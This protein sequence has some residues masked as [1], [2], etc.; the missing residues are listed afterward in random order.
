MARL[1]RKSSF[2]GKLQEDFPVCAHVC[3]YLCRVRSPP[4]STVAMSDLDSLLDSVSLDDL[5]GG[6]AKAGADGQSST[7]NPSSFYFDKVFSQV[8]SRLNVC[9]S[10][11]KDSARLLKSLGD[12][13]A[14]EL[15]EEA[16]RRKLEGLR[17]RTEL[18][19]I[20]M[21]EF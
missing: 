1:G 6:A 15:L 12:V 4:L 7:D 5:S 18:Q 21:K 9:P 8:Q 3:C 16:M 11:S 2:V 10:K 13:Y 17:E 20:F 19:D 14:S